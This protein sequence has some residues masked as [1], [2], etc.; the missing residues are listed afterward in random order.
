MRLLV[1]H[2]YRDYMVDVFEVDGKPYYELHFRSFSRPYKKR[3]YP[4]THGVMD[5]EFT[6]RLQREIDW[7]Y[8][9]QEAVRQKYKKYS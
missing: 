8:E 9:M 3:W 7:D 6:N 2:V 4:C 1:T 5:K